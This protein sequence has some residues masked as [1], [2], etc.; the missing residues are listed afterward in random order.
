MQMRLTSSE[1][2]ENIS[3]N[4]QYDLPELTSWQFLSIEHSRDFFFWVDM[5]MK[6]NR[7][8]QFPNLAKIFN[9]TL[10]F[11]TFQNRSC[12]SITSKLSQQCM[13]NWMAKQF[14]QINIQLHVTQNR[15]AQHLVNL[16]C[17]VFSSTMN[18]RRWWSNTP[19][20][21]S[22]SFNF[23]LMYYTNLKAPV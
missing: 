8:R 20:V 14:I 10:T 12:F 2:N 16:V 7:W 6:S 23:L 13:W 11:L 3:H 5:Q 9:K 21:K 17:R 18:Y 15:W 19:N 4:W 1:I 22:K